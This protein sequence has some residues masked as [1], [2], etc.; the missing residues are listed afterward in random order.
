MSKLADDM[1]AR[2][3]RYIELRDGV[4]YTGYDTLVVDAVFLKTLLNRMCE[5]AGNSEDKIYLEYTVKFNQWKRNYI[6]MCDSKREKKIKK[7]E[8]C[9]AKCVQILSSQLDEDSI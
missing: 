9:A 6:R 8:A 3:L 2:I 1:F 7:L 4:D 5:K